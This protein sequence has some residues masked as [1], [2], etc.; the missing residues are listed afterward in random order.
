V[1]GRDH[2]T[3]GSGVSLPP[4]SETESMRDGA[5]VGLLTGHCSTRC[6]IAPARHLGHC[7]TGCGVGHGLFPNMPGMVIVCDGNA[8]GPR[9]DRPGACGNDP[10]TVR[11]AMPMRLRI[12]IGARGKNASI[13]RV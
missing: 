11:D 9:A 1:I 7:L 3:P 10:A 5:A 6:S 12:A 8:R 13:C 4:T 2:L